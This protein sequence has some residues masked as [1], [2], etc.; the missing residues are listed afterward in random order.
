[1][2]RQLPTTSLLQL[3]EI[4]THYE[5]LFVLPGTFSEEEVAPV[6]AKV[7][8]IVTTAGATNM[9]MHDL[10]KNRLAYPMKHIRYG[11]YRICR[12]EAEG[13]AV[14]QMQAKLRLIGELLRAVVQTYNPETD[15][16][17]ITQE[18]NAQPKGAPAQQGADLT[19]PEMAQAPVAKKKAAKPAE[20]T[21][22]EEKV[23][24]ENIDKKLD[25]ILD[26]DIASV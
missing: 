23:S 12:F 3:L 10:G 14:P 24:M 1:M 2:R 18:R 21:K 5:L 15:A 9:E 19:L 26:K 25:E 11:Y 13:D 8:E 20:E 22:E 17:V 16:P 7:E 6:V 4:M